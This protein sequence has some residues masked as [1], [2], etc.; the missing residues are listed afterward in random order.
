MSLQKTAERRL[1]S[2]ARVLSFV[3][4]ALLIV[5]AGIYSLYAIEGI[6]LT[7]VVFTNDV[8]GYNTSLNTTNPN[9]S[10]TTSTTHVGP[11]N[12]STTPIGSLPIGTYFAFLKWS[13][14]IDLALVWFLVIF[15]LFSILRPSNLRDP[16]KL[17]DVFY[18]NLLFGVVFWPIAALGAYF[19]TMAP[20]VML[21]VGFLPAIVLTRF[22]ARFVEEGIGSILLFAIIIAC[23]ALVMIMNVILWAAFLGGLGLLL[24]VLLQFVPILIFLLMAFLDRA[25][26][27]RSRPL[28]GELLLWGGVGVVLSA[29]VGIAFMGSFSGAAFDILT[30]TSL[31]TG[32]TVLLAPQMTPWTFIHGIASSS[33]AIFVAEVVPLIFGLTGIL[34]AV[35]SIPP[36]LAVR[37]FLMV[38]NG[39]SMADECKRCKR[40]YIV[41]KSR[42]NGYCER[43]RVQPQVLRAVRGAS[44]IPS[45]PLSSPPMAPP[46]PPAPG[47]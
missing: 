45:S 10:V 7:Q 29:A 33:F 15:T 23:M 4:V 3:V 46:P 13:V 31:F 36:L 26:P 17:L 39:T 20:A 27:I 44:A 12:N 37:D 9:G 16:T 30:I 25:E 41:M 2:R 43:C 14:L 35:M 18:A 42:N 21:A 24:V 32:S 11:S 19:G 38:R 6:G 8:T 34:T 28:V 5:T 47:S 22:L 1:L 40:A